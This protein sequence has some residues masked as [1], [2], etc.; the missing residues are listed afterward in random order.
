VNVNVNM[1]MVLR[2]APQKFTTFTIFATFANFA[3]FAKFANFNLALEYPTLLP[4]QVP[5]ARSISDCT[6]PTPRPLV[7]S[8]NVVV[9]W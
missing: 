6:L 8:K 7:C 4:R 2:P 9:V 5:P 1:K 3:K